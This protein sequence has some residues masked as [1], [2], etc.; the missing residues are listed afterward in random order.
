MPAL[1]SHV[2]RYLAAVPVELF[3]PLV[4]TKVL[5]T[6]SSLPNPIQY[7]QYTH[8]TAGEWLLFSPDTWTSG[9]L[10]VTLYALNSR[11]SLC[12]ATHDNKLGIADWLTLGRSTSSGLIGLETSN[13]LGHDVGFISMAFQE[14]LLMYVK[15]GK[16]HELTIL[17]QPE[18]RNGKVRCQR[19]RS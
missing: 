7:P 1:L 17:Q 14:E 9:F 8:T 4:P 19:L 13:T 3:S 16:D 5:A 10:P 18:E 11:N 2:V 12:G 6:V 15:S